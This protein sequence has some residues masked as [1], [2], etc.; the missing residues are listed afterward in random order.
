MTY[1]ILQWDSDFF[2]FRVARIIQSPMTELQIAEVLSELQRQRIR[3]VY[4]ASEHSWDAS[5]CKKQNGQLVDIKTRFSIDL[6]SAHLDMR[7]THTIVERFDQSM[8]AH[9][10]EDLA[11]QSGAYS[12][13]SI[14]PLIPRERFIALYKIWM[15]RTL[16]KEIAKEVLV[17]REANRVVGMVTLGENTGFGDIGLIAV[18]SD[19]RGKKYGET[20]VRAAQSWFFAHGYRFGQVITQGANLPACNLYRKCGFAVEK[21]EFFYHIWL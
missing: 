6:R 3:L 7:D 19:S 9:D 10:L 17:I 18:A 16:A 21:I 13:Y 8:S 20:L 14:D 4:W 2:G 1:Q 15:S 11:I 5:E 12:R